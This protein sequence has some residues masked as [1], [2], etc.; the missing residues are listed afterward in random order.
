[1]EWWGKFH[2]LGQSAACSVSTEHLQ[3]LWVGPD[4]S[5]ERTF[6]GG[7]VTILGNLHTGDAL[8]GDS[9]QSLVNLLPHLFGFLGDKNISKDKGACFVA[10]LQLETSEWIPGW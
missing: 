9:I 4:R 3:F 7:E 8:I 5:I 1:M 6:A 10:G 2:E